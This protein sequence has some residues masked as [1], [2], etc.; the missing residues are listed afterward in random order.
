MMQRSEEGKRDLR[1]RERERD[2]LKQTKL[3]EHKTDKNKKTMFR[4]HSQSSVFFF[5]FFF[6]LSSQPSSFF[7]QVHKRENKIINYNSFDFLLPN[8]PNPKTTKIIDH[9][10][11][12]LS[13]YTLWRRESLSVLA[14]PLS[15]LH[16]SRVFFVA[17]VAI[18]LP[19]I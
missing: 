6:L 9:V 3:R 5:F 13:L 2:L 4:V 8:F 7:Y 19:K 17:K 12:S 18:I 11:L 10:T 14:S 16:S 1:E 15:P